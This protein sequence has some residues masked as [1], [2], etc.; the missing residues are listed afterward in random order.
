MDESLCSSENDFD[1]S[2]TTG[3]VSAQIRLAVY[4][5]LPQMTS[6]HDVLYGIAHHQQVDID[7]GR[8]DDE[9]GSAGCFAIALQA[10]LF[11]EPL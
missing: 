1:S 4:P 9:S 6:Y 10:A 8:R 7:K 5:K 3:T 2:G 11:A